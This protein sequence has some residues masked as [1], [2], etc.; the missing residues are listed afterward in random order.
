[1]VSRR[2]CFAVAAVALQLEGE[3]AMQGPL[4]DISLRHDNGED[5]RFR[6]RLFSECSWYDEEHGMLCRQKLYVT[7]DRDQIYYIMRTGAEER[8][9]HAYR[10]RV[11]DDVCTIDNGKG[12]MRMP[13]SLLMLA[14]RALCGMDAQ[15]A[16]S[17]AMVEEMLKAANA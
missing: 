14:V 10:L 8:S 15:S 9:R 13:V 6:G 5:M 1:M 4:E 11:Q 2:P 3:D 12:E 17:L 16:D 7:E